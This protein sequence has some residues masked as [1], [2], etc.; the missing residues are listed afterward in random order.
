[1]T[2]LTVMQSIVHSTMQALVG[3]SRQRRI[4]GEILIPLPDPLPLGEPFRTAPDGTRLF[5]PQWNQPSLAPIND[6]FINRATDLIIESEQVSAN[7]NFRRH[8]NMYTHMFVMQRQP[9]LGTSP[10]RSDVV[11]ACRQYF[12][13]MRGDYNAQTS[14][15]ARD[16]KNQKNTKNSRRNRKK[17]VSL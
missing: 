4:N 1:M 17:K 5:N 9:S 10:A 14:T 12:R 13:T 15:V 11:H 6:D 16:K 3:V 8:I 2:M 7:Y